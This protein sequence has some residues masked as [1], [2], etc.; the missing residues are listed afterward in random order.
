MKDSSL[1]LYGDDDDYLNGTSYARY[2]FVALVVLLVA[3]IG[4]LGIWNYYKPVHG[5]RIPLPADLEAAIRKKFVEKEKRQ[6]VSSETYHC[7]SVTLMSVTVD[8]P[9]YVTLIDAGGDEIE[10]DIRSKSS[11][12][13]LNMD[14]WFVAI[15]SRE[16]L[17]SSPDSAIDGWYIF[18]INDYNR[19]RGRDKDGSPC[20]R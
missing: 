3:A 16:Q 17:S 18:L 13:K 9:N 2:I 19:L 20:L 7:D 4:V 10:F 14:K 12:V 1:N 5:E 6:I 15:S 11:P 8:K